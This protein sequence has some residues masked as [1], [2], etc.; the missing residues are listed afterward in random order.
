MERKN[1]WTLKDKLAGLILIERFYLILFFLIYPL[2]VLSLSGVNI[3][4]GYIIFFV[5]GIF[6]I[7]YFVISNKIL[8]KKR[9]YFQ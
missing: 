6:L 9:R 4:F 5:L 7:Y 1:K 3:F 2:I 8:N